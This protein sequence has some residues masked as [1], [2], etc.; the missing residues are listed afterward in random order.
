VKYGGQT[1]SD[2]ITRFGRSKLA[3]VI[4]VPL[5]LRLGED[6]AGQPVTLSSEAFRQLPLSYQDTY[7]AMQDQ[8]IPAGAA[9]GLLSTFGA[10]LQTYT[11]RPAKLKG[12]V[13]SSPVK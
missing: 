10:G 5:D 11:P 4:A 1:L 3:P 2:V 9:L 13:K 12:Q 7:Q 8:G 6:V